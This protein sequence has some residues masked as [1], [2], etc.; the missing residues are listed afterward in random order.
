MKTPE[1]KEFKRVHWEA[2]K[3]VEYLYPELEF[4]MEVGWLLAEDRSTRWVLT[5]TCILSD[6]MDE[7]ALMEAKI[8][9]MLKQVG[10]K[11]LVR[12]E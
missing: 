10:I 9:D 3:V 8:R 12:V 5:I 1:K 2:R 6:E 11:A 7:C 4:Y